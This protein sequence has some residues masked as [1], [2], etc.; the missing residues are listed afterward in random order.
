MRTQF[1]II[2]IFLS[3]FLSIGAH[4]QRNYLQN[5]ITDEGLSA[6]LIVNQKWVAYPDYKNRNAW[7]LFWGVNKDSVIHSGEQVLDYQ[8]KPILAMSYLEFKKSGSRDEMQAPFMKNAQTVATLFY[9]ELAEGKGRF[10]PQIINGVMQMCEMTSWTVS[11][12]LHYQKSGYSFPDHREHYIDLVAARVGSMLSWVYFFLA[13]EFDKENPLIALR[14]RKELQERILDTYM[15]ENH[16]WW[17][18]FNATP[19]TM[20]NNWNPW[21]NSNVLQC[22]MLL[23]NDRDRL[24]KAVSRTMV[25]VD[26]FINYVKSDGACEEGPVYWGHAAGKLY[27]YLQL[28]KMIT[29]GKA[30]VF[31]KPLIKDMGE[32]IARSFIGDGWVVNFADASARGG[33]EP[34][35]IFRYGRAVNSDEMCRYAS[36]ILRHGFVKKT[37]LI[38]TYRI[39]ESVV[40]EDSIKATSSSLTPSEYSWYPETQFCYMRD[41]ANQY[42]FAGKGG[43]NNE[44]HNHN[45]AGSFIFFVNDN[46]VFID[47]GVGTYTRQTFSNER[48]KIW[49][50]TSDYH[51][52]PNINGYAQKFGS[53]YKATNV[54][55]EPDNKTFSAEIGAAYPQEAAINFWKRTYKFEA[56]NFVI[57]DNYSLK[58]VTGPT[59]IYFQ[60][61]ADVIVTKPGVLS[62]I[63]DDAELRFEYD[64]DL[65]EFSKEKIIL[66]DIKFSSV[67]G[68]EITRLKFKIRNRSKNGKSSFKLSRQRVTR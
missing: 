14:L 37:E 62:L 40:Y 39:L 53:K 47:A 15:T 60:T 26:K 56:D 30:D 7:D 44:S 1:V 31:Q 12:H 5:C 38:D 32:Y 33:G 11:A 24:S 54:I 28:L 4:T 49:S 50:M 17:M 6:S 25:S 59:T 27:D 35:L 3:S 13:D 43:Y 51:N 2:T 19:E 67:W 55:F 61:I 29:D 46:P 48:Y 36:Y 68:S 9:A 18:A 52:L 45:D 57:S 42:F 63:K 20:V 64:T 10:V 65:F 58:K 41:T 22:F 21:C 16:F 34:A 66:D 23:E 8:W